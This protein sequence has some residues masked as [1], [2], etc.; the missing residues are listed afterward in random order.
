MSRTGRSGQ[1]GCARI[2]VAGSESKTPSV[3]RRVIFI[4]MG[5]FAVLA[6]S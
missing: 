3:K 2:C 6:V 4:I 1:A 5:L